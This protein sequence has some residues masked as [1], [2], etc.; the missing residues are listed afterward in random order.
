MNN[1]D[2]KKFIESITS[3][4]QRLQKKHGIFASVT[5]AQACLETGYGKHTPKDKRT[6]KESYN[7]FGIKGEGDNGHVTSTTWEVVKGNKVTIDANF[8]AYK[9]YYGS[10][11]DHA[12]VLLND[13][14]KPVIQAK[15]GLTAVKQLHPC[16]Y[17]TDHSYGDK[18]IAI[19]EQFD[20][21]KCDKII[22]KTHT[23]KPGDTLSEI[24]DKYNTLVDTLVK[25]NNIKDPGKIAVGQVIKLP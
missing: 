17:A 20:L 8:R 1:I 23:V 3:D 4:A 5:I 24:A 9:S 10:L 21:L 18:L 16:G 22:P 2:A 7:L 12:K 25:L 6:G 15:D 19:I 13:R 14:Y 11:Y